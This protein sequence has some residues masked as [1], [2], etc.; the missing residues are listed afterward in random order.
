MGNLLIRTLRLAAASLLGLTKNCWVWPQV[1]QLA[2][3]QGQE[4]QEQ[5]LQPCS[6]PVLSQAIRQPVAFFF[7]FSLWLFFSPLKL[8]LTQLIL[9]LLMLHPPWVGMWGGEEGGCFLSGPYTPWW[10]T[11][12]PSTSPS[13]DLVG[14]L[15]E[16]YSF[17]SLSLFFIQ[18]P[19][20]S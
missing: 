10:M 15:L 7:Y 20:M 18:P 1:R 4:A 12:A 16:A 3:D 17:L 13:G 9:V 19:T 6:L 5:R 14:I 11:I 2:S 8:P